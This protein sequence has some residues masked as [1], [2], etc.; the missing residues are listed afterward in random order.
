[1]QHFV[2]LYKLKPRLGMLWTLCHVVKSQRGD[3]YI[4]IVVK[5]KRITKKQDLNTGH[6]NWMSKKTGKDRPLNT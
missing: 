5:I 3:K 4:K 2:L 1:M 6:G